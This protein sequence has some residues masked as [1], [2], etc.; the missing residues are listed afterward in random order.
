MRHL[1]RIALGL[2]ALFLTCLTA[3]PAFAADRPPNI[4]LILADDLGY[5]DFSCYGQEMF[6]TPNIDRLAAEGMRFT[7]FYV[8]TVCSPTRSCLLT[9]MH[10][11][12]ARI[13]ANRGTENQRVNIRL[14]KDPTISE[15]L[16]KG[17]YR[18][19]VVGKWH[20]S[21]LFTN[22]R[23]LDKGFDFHFG[24]MNTLDG[25]DYPS[26]FWLNKNT[27]KPEPDDWDH[28]LYTHFAKEFIRSSKD[29]PFFL[30]LAYKTG[31]AHAE[32]RQN[33]A[34]IPIDPIYAKKD[35]PYTA[36]RQA[37][38]ITEMDRDIGEITDLIDELGLGENTL[39]IFTS[40]NGP[41]KEDGNDP[42]FFNSSGAVR[43]IKRD[44]YEG[45][46]RVPM[47]ARWK[48]TIAAGQVSDHISAIWDFMP[49]ALDMA[50][51]QVPANIDGI[52]FLPELLGNEQPKH[53][54][55]YWQ[56]AH[57]KSFKEAI[58]VG[59]WKGV[60]Q[61]IDS[62][63]ELFDLETDLREMNDLADQYPSYVKYL[64]KLMGEAHTD[65][66]EYLSRP[67]VAQK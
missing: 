19:G 17:G 48:G 8:N 9:G 30:Y 13:R 45:G 63:I 54:Y 28:D 16:Q 32:I 56:Y 53:A 35:W 6:Q 7:Q 49:T 37:T 57:R 21:Y 1:T 23:P 39:I 10:P 50:G 66:P 61:T 42:N 12:H 47:I 64:D 4:V 43:G 29:R 15:M 24:K 52:S 5:G 38:M 65:N 31:H 67:P 40:D 3:S 34:P 62:P 18:T 2:A 27:Y 36:K 11:G 41:H 22:G 25:Y 26:P 58:R 14:G 55:L 59:R 44:M 33:G 46:I 51:L 60:R 20:V